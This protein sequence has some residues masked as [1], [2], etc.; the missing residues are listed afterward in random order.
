MQMPDVQ[1]SNQ[2]MTHKHAEE[3]GTPLERE[4]GWKNVICVTALHIKYKSRI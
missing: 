4:P 1:L 3:Q 2:E